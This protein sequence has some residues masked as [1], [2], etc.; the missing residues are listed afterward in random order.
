MASASVSSMVRLMEWCLFHFWWVRGSPFPSI[1]ARCSVLGVGPAPVPGA[2][3]PAECRAHASKNPHM[4]Y[5]RS[6]QRFPRRLQ[7]TPIRLQSSN[8]CRPPLGDR[9]WMPDAQDLH[10]LPVTP[11]VVD[12]I[13]FHPGWKPSDHLPSVPFAPFRQGHRLSRPR[14]DAPTTLASSPHTAHLSRLRQIPGPAP[15]PSG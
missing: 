9:L 5:A 6:L 7:R 13:G 8:R 4:G 14:V 11:Q 2:R 15:S 12:P 3:Y 10:P 1:G